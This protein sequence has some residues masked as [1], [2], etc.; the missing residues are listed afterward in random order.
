MAHRTELKNALAWSCS[1]V[2]ALN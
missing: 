1:S 2:Y